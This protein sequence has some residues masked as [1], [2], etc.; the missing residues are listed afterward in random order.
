MLSFLLLLLVQYSPLGYIARNKAI[1]IIMS[2]CISLQTVKFCMCI[3][4]LHGFLFTISILLVV[5]TSPIAMVSLTFLWLSYVDTE[6]KHNLY[7]PSFSFCVRECDWDLYPPH[8][9]HVD[10]SGSQWPSCQARLAGL[11]SSPVQSTGMQANFPV[12]YSAPPIPAGIWLFHWNPQEFCWNSTR[13][14]LCLAMRIQLYS[15]F[16]GRWYYFHQTQIN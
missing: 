7:V 1:Q 5:D 16:D 4:L 11:D 13:I 2:L 9:I 3:Y 8:I 6:E 10:S 12:L 15:H 14:K